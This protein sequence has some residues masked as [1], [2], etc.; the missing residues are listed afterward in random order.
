[1]IAEKSKL[2]GGSSLASAGTGT[3]LG[4]VGTDTSLAST[5]LVTGLELRVPARSGRG[6]VE[7]RFE[8]ASAGSTC[9][10]SRLKRFG[11]GLPFA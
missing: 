3:S 8:A 2:T 10:F 5:G 7:L 4:S 9:G 11:L 1:M 6:H